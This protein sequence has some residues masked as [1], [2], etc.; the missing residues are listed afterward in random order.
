MKKYALLGGDQV[1]FG[2]ASCLLVVGS[3]L[4]LTIFPVFVIIMLSTSSV[5][6]IF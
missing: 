6:I 3:E 1:A 2:S 4:V 5:Q